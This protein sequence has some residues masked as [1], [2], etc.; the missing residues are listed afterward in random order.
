MPAVAKDPSEECQRMS[1]GRGKHRA[2]LVTK[3]ASMWQAAGQR[4]AVTVGGM[5]GPAQPGRWQGEE[6]DGCPVAL[7]ARDR[8]LEEGSSEAAFPDT[9]IQINTLTHTESFPQ[10]RS[11]MA[12]EGLRTH[13]NARKL[14][15]SLQTDVGPRTHL[16]S[17]LAPVAWRPLQL[18]V[19]SVPSPLSSGSQSGGR[20]L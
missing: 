12:L 6:T 5:P 3:K 2:K 19:S 15:D 8:G 16:H 10:L 4:E 20:R 1:S 17:T 18:V 9:R 7:R 14:W 11:R 13:S